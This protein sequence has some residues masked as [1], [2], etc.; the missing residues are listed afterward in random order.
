MLRQVFVNLIG[1]ALK[2]SSRSP[3]PR[4]EVFVESRRGIAA[5]CVRDNGVGFDPAYAD[6]LFGVFQRMHGAEEFPGTGVGLAIVKRIV[7][8]HGGVIGVEAAPGRGATFRFTLA[9][10]RP[11]DQA[12]AVPADAPARTGTVPRTGT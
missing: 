11:F 2:F 8:R 7:E 4:V 10:F 3:Q 5:I 9:G 12:D 6:R 1:N